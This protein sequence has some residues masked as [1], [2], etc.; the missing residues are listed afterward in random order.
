MV[1]W[2]VDGV[3]IVG[4]GF[5]A[6]LPQLGIRREDTSAFFLGP[7]QECLLGRARLADVLPPFLQQWGWA[8][9]VDSF[10]KTWFDSE[11][12][13]NDAAWAWLTRL[14]EWHVPQ[15]LAT[16]QE[17]T[18]LA[19]L[20]DDLGLGSLVTGTLASSD[21]GARKP[22]PVYFARALIQSGAP[23]PARVLFW[24]DQIANVQA[25]AAAGIQAAWYQSPE[26]LGAEMTAVTFTRGPRR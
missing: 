11:R 4:E 6:L 20:M 15:Y 8:G 22:D 12:T 13:K 18:R 9:G 3:L 7:F 25:A 1:W 10:L 19:L 21:L 16:N 24:D 2:D 23:D 5:S 14:A 17:A 26:Q